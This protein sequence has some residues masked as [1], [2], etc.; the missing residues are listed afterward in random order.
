MKKVFFIFASLLLLSLYACSSKNKNEENKQA[1]DTTAGLP[2]TLP[3]AQIDE[4][5]LNLVKEIRPAKFVMYATDVEKH[6]RDK[7][8][9]QIEEGKDFAGFLPHQ[10]IVEMGIP[11]TE[12]S[13]EHKVWI[14]N[15]WVQQNFILLLL[16]ASPNGMLQEQTD[17]YL[18]TFSLEGNFLDYISWASFA[19]ISPSIDRKSFSVWN[20]YEIKAHFEDIFYTMTNQKRFVKTIIEYQINEKGIFE[21]ILHTKRESLEEGENIDIEEEKSI[22][23]IYT[24]FPFQPEG[25]SLSDKNLKVKE[26]AGNAF[27]EL[28]QSDEMSPPKLVYFTYFTDNSE[29]KTFGYQYFAQGT[30]GASDHE[31]QFYR[32]EGK[33]WRN[34]TDEICPQLSF[35]D[36][37]D[38]TNEMPSLKIR[39]HFQLKYQ[40][41]QVGTSIL[42]T[43]EE[44]PLVDSGIDFEEFEKVKKQIRYKT[45]E[46]KWNM[47]KGVFELGKKR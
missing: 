24:L 17:Y 20:E 43:L 41:P 22:S 15:K 46:L 35:K 23:K 2:E 40:L 1:I 38:S 45:I 28:E 6:F 12:F 9:P 21:K 47:E 30:V 5:F 29:K 8:A 14:Q 25:F 31:I 7:I 26:D 11:Q 13:K 4:K 33:K 44:Q 18:L 42:V 16:G 34:I 3:Q 39:N 36:F 27:L 32:V 10:L 37:W 19:E